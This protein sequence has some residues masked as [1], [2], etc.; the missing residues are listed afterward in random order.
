METSSRKGF[1]LIELLVVIAIVGILAAIT[2]GGFNI[3]REKARFA[4]AKQE[5]HNIHNAVQLYITEYGNYPS[6]AARGVAPAGLAQY[7]SGGVWPTPPWPG[8]YFDWDR[9]DNQGIYQISVRFCPAGSVD[10]LACQ[11]PEESW[12]SGFNVDSSVY[13][14]ISGPCKAHIGQPPSYPGYCI[15]NCP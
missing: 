1:S 10:T 3:A 12:A 8:S 5:F 13:Y 6:D 2:V 15:Y 7:L 4:V 9:D 14:C 11:F